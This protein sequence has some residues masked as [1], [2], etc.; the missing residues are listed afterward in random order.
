MEVLATNAT[1]A[2]ST[3]TSRTIFHDRRTMA[4]SCRGSTRC[5]PL[6]RVSHRCWGAVRDGQYM[7]YPLSNPPK[8]PGAVTAVT[9]RSRGSA[10]LGA[11]EIRDELACR[12]R[13]GVAADGVGLD[14]AQA[15]DRAERLLAEPAPVGLA[16]IG[17]KEMGDLPLHGGRRQ[18]NV[19]IR[20]AQIALVLDDL[21]LE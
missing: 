20:L 10:R 18:G 11:T 17:R 9:G 13:L 12:E 5:C 3:P 15:Q 1:T 6:P 4:S 16:G 19:E 21:V 7:R 2:A 8:R 14:A